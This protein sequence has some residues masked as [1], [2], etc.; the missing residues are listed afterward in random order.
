MRLHWS[1]L[2]ATVAVVVSLTAV[3]PAAASRAA[4]PG[5][6]TAG[7]SCPPST[8]VVTVTCDEAAF[9]RRGGIVARE[10]FEVTR[11][12]DP[13]R[14]VVPFSGMKFVS[15]DAADPS[16]SVDPIGTANGKL[17]RKFSDGTDTTSNA[18]IYFAGRGSVEQVGLLLHPFGYPNQF[19]IRVVRVDGREIDL[20]LP[21]DTGDVYLGLSSDV[22]IKKVKILQQPWLAGGG[23]T[24][25]G[26]DNVSRGAITPPAS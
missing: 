10:T 17:Y 8:S 9:L 12:F 24:N 5:A 2:A 20:K 1:G 15:W 16:W 19:V 13:A 3:A 21:R 4:A 14:K 22:G 6:A 7:S 26:L 11:V 23:S 18:S 25:F